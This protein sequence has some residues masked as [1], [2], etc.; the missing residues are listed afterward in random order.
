MGFCDIQAVTTEQSV[1]P[2][3][4]PEV[5]EAEA[6]RWA[7]VISGQLQLNKE[8]F[9]GVSK[10]CVEAIIPKVELLVGNLQLLFWTLLVCQL[11]LIFVVLTGFPPPKAANQAPHVLGEWALLNSFVG[12]LW[13]F[14]ESLFCVGFFL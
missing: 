9:A 7:F 6:F 4:E 11:N 10:L 1:F 13:D 5:A 8:Y 14:S 3:T 2:N 12:Q